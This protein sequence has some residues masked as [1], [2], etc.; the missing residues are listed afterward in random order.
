[1][2]LTKTKKKYTRDGHTI[3]LHF[4]L[5]TINHWAA[6]KKCNNQNN[7]MS[8]WLTQSRRTIWSMKTRQTAAELRR[9]RELHLLLMSFTAQQDAGGKG[10]WKAQ[11]TRV[12]ALSSTFLGAVFSAREIKNPMNSSLVFL[13]LRVL[14]LGQY[15][16]AGRLRIAHAPR[17]LLLHMS[18]VSRPK[19][20]SHRHLD[21]S[22]WLSC[23]ERFYDLWL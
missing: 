7:E 19:Y 4:F 22:V 10:C 3:I 2:N 9:S 17:Y 1:M 21:S 6:S 8:A 18:D 13:T 14:L 23:K 12:V 11:K 5:K 16:E 15:I 20:F